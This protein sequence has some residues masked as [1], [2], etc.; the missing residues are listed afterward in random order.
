MSKKLLEKPN[1]I[2]SFVENIIETQENEIN[3]LK[4]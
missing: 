4:S 1:N 2:Q 3:I